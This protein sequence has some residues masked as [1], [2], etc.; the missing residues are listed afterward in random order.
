RFTG[1]TSAFQPT[2]TRATAVTGSPTRSPRS[3]AMPTPEHPSSKRSSSTWRRCDGRDPDHSGRLGRPKAP[4]QGAAGAPG[5]RAP[6]A[7]F[8]RRA[9]GRP[10]EGI[11]GSGIGPARRSADDLATGP[12]R[13]LCARCGASWGYPRMTC[14]GC[15]EDESTKLPVFSEYGTASG[16]RG[17]VVRGLPA[18][19]VADPVHAVFPH[20]RIEACE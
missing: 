8:L 7:G 18:D 15:G 19:A 20:V 1:A 13:L 6:A 17:S 11:R 9:A 10:G 14:P 12:R 4:R 5:I 16:E 3:W 2:A